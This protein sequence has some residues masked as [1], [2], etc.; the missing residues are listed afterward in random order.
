M[1]LTTLYVLVGVL[2]LFIGASLFWYLQYVTHKATMRRI[3]MEQ[4]EAARE[5]YRH[6]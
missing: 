1:I 5:L 3:A 2:P 6:E 4:W